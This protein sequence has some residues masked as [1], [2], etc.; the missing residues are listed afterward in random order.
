[1]RSH[2]LDFYS[3]V[4]SFR[5]FIF[6][7]WCKSTFK[8]Y[9][10]EIFLKNLV[11]CWHLEGQW[12]KYKDPDP[13]PVPEMGKIRIRDKKNYLLGTLRS[14]GVSTIMAP[15]L[16]CCEAPVFWLLISAAR[17]RRLARA[18]LAGRRG[19]SAGVV[20]AGVAVAGVAVAGVAVAVAGVMSRS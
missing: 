4:S 3:F 16:F 10:V 11:F 6:E 15:V 12:W 13:H 2:D 18:V 1:M 14:P 7:K 17:S 8:K 20:E 9:F 5:L 19:V